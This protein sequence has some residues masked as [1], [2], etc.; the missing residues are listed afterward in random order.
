MKVTFIKTPDGRSMF[1]HLG[2]TY[3]MAAVEAA[4][5]EVEYIDANAIDFPW[6]VLERN[7]LD[8]GDVDPDWP[9]LEEYLRSRNIRVALL[10]GMFTPFFPGT[11]RTAQL[12]K[13]INPEYTVIVGGV[14]VSSLPWHTM[15]TY[16]VFD[17]V[18]LHE[19]EESTPELLGRLRDGRSVEGIGGIAYRKGGQVIVEPNRHPIEPLDRIPFPAKHLWP[20]DVY[21]RCWKHLEKEDPAGTIIATR[22]CVGKCKFCVSGYDSILTRT[23][24]RAPQN[25]FAEIEQL[26]QAFDVKSIHFIDDCFTTKKSLA[27]E[28]CRYLKE[29]KLPWRCKSRFDTVTPDLMHT[30]K[31][32]GCVG[33]YLGIESV[34]PS[35]QRSMGKFVSLEKI[36]RNIWAFREV[37][38]DFAVSFTIGHHG[39]TRAQ[40][41]ETVRFACQLARQGVK[42]GFYL[43]T[44]YPRTAL[45]EMAVKNGWMYLEDPADW[46]QFDQMGHGLPIYAPE[47]WSPAELQA[48]Y[49]SSWKRVD[50]ARLVY[51]LRDPRY[52]ANWAVRAVSSPVKAGQQVVRVTRR[53]VRGLALH[54]TS[55]FGG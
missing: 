20:M 54:R 47:G 40:M 2:F 19:G 46:T 42:V 53:L 5:Y 29:R 14:H 22:G 8:L 4:G 41:E 34:D 17:Y 45:Y 36:R 35:I 43:I 21:R 37:G 32:S 38:L 10:T 16:P 48:Y 28:V 15:E 55:T 7:P 3:V 9:K 1:P 6:D 31:E 13:K 44:P 24:F 12:L 52:M 51:R 18:V 26:I 30:M 23:R 27:T 25:I 50:R 39:E 49:R 33:M 11:V